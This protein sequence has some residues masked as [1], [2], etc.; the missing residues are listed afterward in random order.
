MSTTAFGEASI[1]TPALSDALRLQEGPLSI[2]SQVNN[3]HPLEGRVKNWEETQQ[4]TRMEMYR[5]V[6]GAGEPIRREMEMQ[7]VDATDFKPAILGGSDSLHRDILTNRES[8]VDWEDIYKGGYE[9]G[10]NISD[11]HSEME[12]KVGI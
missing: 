2:A 8:T 3:R 7:I 12:R 1:N 4:Q 10:R 11:F 6:F 5:R 9:S